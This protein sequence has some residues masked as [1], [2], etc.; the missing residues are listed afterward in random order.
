MPRNVIGC[1]IGLV[2]LACLR[3][4][5]HGLSVKTIDSL[6]VGFFSKPHA[7]LPEV[8]QRHLQVDTSAALMEPASSG[9]LHGL[10]NASYLEQIDE[11]Y[12]VGETEG[13][14]RCAAAR[15]ALPRRTGRVVPTAAAAAHRA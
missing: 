8:E 3:A 2:G 10:R 9:L 5:I 11:A 12:G 7:C 1:P 14:A 15:P 4:H 6:H 13:L